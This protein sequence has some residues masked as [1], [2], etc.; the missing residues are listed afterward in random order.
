MDP[1]EP[2]SPNDTGCEALSGYAVAADAGVEVARST[3]GRTR[4]QVARAA[5]SMV[6]GREAAWLIAPGNQFSGPAASADATPAH[7]LHLVVQRAR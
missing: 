5:P 1:K 4:A 2:A 7:A 6:L 3:A